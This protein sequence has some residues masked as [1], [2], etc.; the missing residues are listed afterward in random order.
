MHVPE[1]FTPSKIE[2][3]HEH[4]P[5]TKRYGLLFGC[6]GQWPHHALPRPCDV[7]ISAQRNLL[8]LLESL[9]GPELT[10]NPIQH[11][12]AKP[13][14]EPKGNAGPLST[15]PWHQDAGVMMEEAEG[16]DVVTCWLPVGRATRNGLYGSD[17]GLVE[18]GYLRHLREG[19]TT[20]DPELI[21]SVEPVVAE[22]EKGDLM[23]MVAS[24]HID[25][26]P[27]TRMNVAGRWTC[28]TSQQVNTRDYRSPRLCRP[29]TVKPR[30]RDARL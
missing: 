25:R 20:I 4:E 17:T 26:R 3:L 8:E 13:P 6:R 9:L 7:R 23:L 21:P 14:H 18:T 28:A 1:T 16:S 27:T 29:L 12:R 10:C 11:L 22:C 24:P 19:G 30:Q 5:F 2:D 15:T